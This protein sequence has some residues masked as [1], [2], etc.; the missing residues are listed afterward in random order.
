MVDEADKDSVR[1]VLGKANF[2]SD[3]ELTQYYITDN[4]ESPTLSQNNNNEVN[5]NI[6]FKRKL[7]N[8]AM[9]TFFPSLLLITISYAT[10]FFKLPNFFN[11]AI[12]VNLTVML[13]TTTLL[14][15]VVKKLA[16][17]SYIKWMEAW[18]IFAQ[19][20]PFTQVILITMMEW[21][22]EEKKIDV[23]LQK[24]EEDPVYERSKEHMW[25]NIGHNLVKVKPL[26]KAGLHIF[27]FT[28]WSHLHQK[29]LRGYQ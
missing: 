15:S 28:H 21:I 24:T 22:K 2:E 10:S 23:D 14:I 26:H 7:T 19:L 25:L 18:L 6:V 20:I 9:M 13:T 3:K 12:T 5:M 29:L 4:P 17:T 11:T 1:L 16:P 8:E 27:R